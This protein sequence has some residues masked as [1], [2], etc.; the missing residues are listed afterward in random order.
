MSAIAR[1]GAEVTEGARTSEQLGDTM[2][3]KSKLRSILIVLVLMV[4]LLATGSMIWGHAI[5]SAIAVTGVRVSQ[6]QA[7]L[8][9]AKYRLAQDYAGDNVIDGEL[10]F[11]QGEW[12]SVY[13]RRLDDQLV[14]GYIE[15]GL[16]TETKLSVTNELAEI[17]MQSG[18]KFQHTDVYTARVLC[19]TLSIM[20]D[21]IIDNPEQI[22]YD[23][24]SD[25]LTKT[26]HDR[27]V[28][29][30]LFGRHVRRS[31]NPLV[32]I[33][34]V[35]EGQMLKITVNS[36]GRESEARIVLRSR[37]NL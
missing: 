7:R 34:L 36:E 3:T 37:N 27:N 25:N 17:G 14:Y 6:N 26:F 11:A 10:I 9:I 23:S 1:L 5:K 29:M 2:R 35:E 33:T 4:L 28:D 32:E 16:R 15:N 31:I 22:D 30:I 24:V 20:M 19:A 18:I 21:H 8:G 13:A 12:N